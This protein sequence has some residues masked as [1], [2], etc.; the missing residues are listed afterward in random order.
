MQPATFTIGDLVLTFAETK[1]WDLI[2]ARKEV[3]DG[4]GNVD[5]FEYGLAL[6]WRSAVAGG[7]QGGFKAFCEAV[8]TPQLDA[9]V[10]VAKPFFVK[11]GAASSE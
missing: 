2:Q 11:A 8:P 4:N 5:S 7:F 9:M 6:A 3:R 10:E 1:A